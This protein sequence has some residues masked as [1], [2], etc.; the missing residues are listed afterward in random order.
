V[1]GAR[2]AVRRQCVAVAGRVS[3]VVCAVSSERM[4]TRW[5]SCA[6]AVLV[7]VLV[8]SDRMATA[9]NQTVE[10]KIRDDPD[11]SEV[12]VTVNYFKVNFCSSAYGVV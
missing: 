9:R 4:R 6:S 5:Q 7:I 1:G 11:L 12:R 8:V 2:A 3:T 10:Q